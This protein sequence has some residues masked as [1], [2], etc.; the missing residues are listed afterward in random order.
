ME[1]LILISKPC[2]FREVFGIWNLPGQCLRLSIVWD[3]FLDLHIFLHHQNHIEGVLCIVSICEEDLTQLWITDTKQNALFRF[4]C[5]LFLME[6]GGVTIFNAE[7]ILKH[8][9]L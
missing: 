1:I 9:S 3:S 7:Q 8:K 5:A 4:L 2:V 6:R